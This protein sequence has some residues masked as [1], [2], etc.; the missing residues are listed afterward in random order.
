MSTRREVVEAI[1]EI[2][3]AARKY[4]VTIEEGGAVGLA[5]ALEAR[6]F[7]KRERLLLQLARD[8]APAVRLT[9]RGL[10]R[11]GLHS[12]DDQLDGGHK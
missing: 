7:E 2:N 12:V 5:N 11:R 4:R 1:V 9:P 3:V 6:L 8:R 10:H